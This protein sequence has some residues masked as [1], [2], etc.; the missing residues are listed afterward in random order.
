MAITKT[1]TRRRP[2]SL[3]IQRVRA[4]LDQKH[5]NWRLLAVWVFMCLCALG[6]IARFVFLQIYQA[7]DLISRARQ[8]QVKRIHTFAP[9]RS[10]TDRHGMVLAVDQ[11]VYTVY[12][13]PH[14]FKEPP[15]TIA[16]KI[17]P[18]F[19]RS[20]ESLTQLLSQPTTTVRLERWLSEESAETLKQLNIEGIDLIPQ[21]RRIY[22]HQ[23]LA[24]E[25]TGY[26]DIDHQGQAGL[27]KSQEDLLKRPEYTIEV[28]QD[29]NGRLIPNEVPK[30]AT[31]VDLTSLRLTID[32]RLQR[33]A[34]ELLQKQ[35]NQFSA[36]R[37]TVVVMDSHTGEIL[38]LVTEPTYD[39]NRYFDYHQKPELFKNWAVS[40]LY[41]PGSTFKPINV[42]IALE[43][44]VIR[45]D[46]YIYDEGAIQIGDAVVTNFDGG[47]GGSLS[48]REI[49]AYSSNVGMVHMMERLNRATYYEWLQKLGIDQKTGIDLPAEATGQLKPRDEFL[50]YPIEPAA[51]AFGQGFA[52]TVIKMVQL[53]GILANSGLMV[54]PH[55][56][57]GL[58]DSNGKLT[59]LERPAPR[60]IFSPQTAQQVVQMMTAVVEEGTAQNARIL[61]YHY[62]GKTG[63]AQKANPRGGY[64]SGKITS[65]V[66]ILPATA[67][68]YVAIAVIDEPIG[69]Q[70]LGSTVAAPIVKGILEELITIEGIP[71]THPQELKSPPQP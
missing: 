5:L 46:E 3:G 44:G 48:I 1:K 39:P 37:G 51:A 54:T 36:L 67:P 19:N 40:D 65:Y 18:I 56:V 16:E 25:I 33:R 4:M 35:I 32:A 27:E 63:T 52:L 45:P 10:I 57:Q 60:R 9:R 11:A 61:G 24:A 15:A 70:A 42:A 13:H 20:P 28:L 14:L 55:V 2:T 41:E 62:G 64:T 38:A 29:G 50:N 6:L 69:T 12:A 7:E 66:G 59:A 58:V 43:T 34:R 26:V 68:R 53:H 71:P 47:G 23:D 8:Q 49:L 30:V 21:Q 22:P 31:A 17:A